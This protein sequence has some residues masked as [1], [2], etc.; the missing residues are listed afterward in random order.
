MAKA[1]GEPNLTP[2][3]TEQVLS[4]IVITIV[5]IW[6]TSVTKQPIGVCV[7]LVP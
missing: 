2:G 7:A 3:L 6:R 5:S 1:L 4:S